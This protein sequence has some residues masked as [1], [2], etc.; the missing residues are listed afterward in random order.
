MNKAGL[1][2]GINRYKNYSNATL[3]GCV[4]DLKNHKKFITD[5]LGFKD[6]EFVSLIDNDATKYN[7]IKYLENYINDAKKGNLNYIYFSISS[8]GTQFPN[9]DKAEEADGLDEAYCPSDIGS[10]ISTFIRDNELY[11]LFKELPKEVIV[12]VFADCCHSGDSVRKAKFDNIYRKERYFE[13]PFI[14]ELK[15]QISE[16]KFLFWNNNKKKETKQPLENVILWAGCKSDQTSADASIRG[17]YNGAFTYYLLYKNNNDFSRKNLI[18]NIC[19]D[20]NANGF[21]QQPQLE[22]LDIYKDKKIGEF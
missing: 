20:V 14:K 22:C 13:P 6:T 11:N 16:D 2:I 7:I 10:S 4:N 17:S 21:T 5:K 15:E 12:E 18:S 1:L 9:S 19:Y 8:H 3:K